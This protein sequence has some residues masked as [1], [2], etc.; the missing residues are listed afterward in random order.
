ML[1][2]VV[3]RQIVVRKTGFAFLQVLNLLVTFTLLVKFTSFQLRMGVIM[4]VS[5]IIK[6]K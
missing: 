4:Y 3:S 5:Y 6:L 2:V 1:N